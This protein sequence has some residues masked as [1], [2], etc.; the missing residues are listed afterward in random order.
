M[1]ISKIFWLLAIAVLMTTLNSCSSNASKEVD[2]TI[3]NIP[4]EV[5]GTTDNAKMPV[6]TFE[7]TNHDFGN[8]MQGE[9][10]SYTY[11]FTNTGKAPLVISS[12][13]P[14]CGCTVAQFTKTPIMPNGH[15]TVS[16]NFNT[17]T[18]RGMVQSG[19]IVQANTY[20][21]ETKLTFTATV[22]SK[23]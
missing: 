14:S 13:V 8:L 1:K 18:K 17:E 7:T 16:I 21:S 20:P 23:N 11:K 5:D 6:I 22:N 9:K 15:G 19:V 3:V 2:A 12:V 4:V 10:V